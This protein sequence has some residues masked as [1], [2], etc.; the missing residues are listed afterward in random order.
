M[1]AQV[2]AS[3]SDTSGELG[4][5]VTII[6]SG[7]SEHLSPYHTDFEKVDTSVA[8]HFKAANGGGFNASRRGD[9]MV[10]MP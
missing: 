10:T 2:L 6:D 3:I 1:D 8:K 9:L 5:R 7:C 4:P